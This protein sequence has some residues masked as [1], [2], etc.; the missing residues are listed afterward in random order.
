MAEVVDPTAVRDALVAAGQRYAEVLRRPDVSAGI[1]RLA[2]G[3]ADPQSPHT[4]DEVYVVLSG[5]AVLHSGNADLPVRAGSVVFVPAGEE[6]RFHSITDEL[7][8]VVVFAP[9]EGNRG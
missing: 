2:A 6:H 1:Y 4:E 8:V 5:A 3:E 9:A 7:L